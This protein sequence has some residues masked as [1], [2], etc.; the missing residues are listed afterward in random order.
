ML[1]AYGPRLAM[2]FMFLTL[3][4]MSAEAI[5]TDNTQQ[6]QPMNAGG[7]PMG[8]EPPAAA[9]VEQ[10]KPQKS[11]MMLVIER[12]F[13]ALAIASNIALQLSPMR[14]I[15]EIR[16][17]K[18][19]KGSDGLPYLMI[20]CVAT[21]WV[22]Y[23]SYS[24]WSTG[25]TS[26]QVIIFANI[27]G[28]ILG[29]FYV[30]SFHRNCNDQIRATK[31]RWLYKLAVLV[32]LVQFICILCLPR[33]DGM[34]M[35][36]LVGAV[37]SVGCTAAPLTE[38]SIILKTRDTS[39]WPADFIYV[40]CGGL[41]IWLVTGLLLGDTWVIAPN[42]VGLGICLF[43]LGIMYAFGGDLKPK[44]RLRRDEMTFH[45]IDETAPIFNVDAK[46]SRKGGFEQVGEDHAP[47]ERSG[48]RVM[49]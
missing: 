31:M 20:C 45:V 1:R 19:T 30:Y 15:L 36:G 34:F 17:Y 8:V 47:M 46:L 48:A 29:S 9:P 49:W 14:V 23:A 10:P 12:I 25:N 11:T 38:L 27:L 39:I 24:I 3:L 28:S 37:L 7:E 5:R 26:M 40:N 41:I 33:K 35:L 6:Q 32:T 2:E 21:Q 22:W 18:D 13:Q 42:G 43:Q 16:R 4:V 44:K